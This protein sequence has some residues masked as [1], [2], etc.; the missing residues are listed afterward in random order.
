MISHVGY[1]TYLHIPNEERKQNQPKGGDNNGEKYLSNVSGCSK[2]LSYRT[3]YKLF[4]V[5][6]LRTHWWKKNT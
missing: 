6:E 4:F 2:I 3:A 5:S 1:I